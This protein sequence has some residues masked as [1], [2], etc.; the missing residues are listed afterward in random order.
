MEESQPDDLVKCHEFSGQI[1]EFSRLAPQE[2]IVN[3]LPEQG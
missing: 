1:S 2:R 3:A